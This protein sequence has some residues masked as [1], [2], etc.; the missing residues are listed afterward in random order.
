MYPFIHNNL[1]IIIYTILIAKLIIIA[2]SLTSLYF[3]KFIHD[4]ATR[5]KY[6]SKV[7]YLQDKSEFVLRNLIYIVLLIIFY[8]RDKSTIYL[9]KEL[10]FSIFVYFVFTFIFSNINYFYEASKERA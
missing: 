8:P 6:D 4:K 9:N 10:A 5:E 2:T 1:H 7:I 3:S